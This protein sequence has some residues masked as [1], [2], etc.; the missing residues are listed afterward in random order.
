MCV[1][2]CLMIA[3]IFIYCPS[4]THFFQASQLSESS[5]S[6]LSSQLPFAFSLPWL[7]W[8]SQLAVRGVQGKTPSTWC[9][10]DPMEDG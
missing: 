10:M 9:T 1:C 6:Q 5:R 8:P 2:V 7:P 4:L 3:T